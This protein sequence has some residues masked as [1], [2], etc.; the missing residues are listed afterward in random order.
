ME[1]PTFYAVI[2]AFVR[3]ADISA[4]AKLMYGEVTAL[5]EAKG[6]CWASNGYFGKL[7]NANERTVRRWLNELAA[8]DFVTV[9]AANNQHG[10]DSARCRP[11]F[12]NDLAHRSDLISP[13]IPR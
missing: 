2:P 10:A 1:R 8:A 12:R 3:Y 4:Q 13:T 9:D 7:Y 6:F 11:P 5:C